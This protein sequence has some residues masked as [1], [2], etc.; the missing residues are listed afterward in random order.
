MSFNIMAVV[1]I[2]SDF[3]NAKIKSVTVSIISPSICYEEMRLETMIFIFQMLSFK[4]KFSLS[5]FIKRLFRSSSLSATR[6]VL[7]A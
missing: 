6:V 5:S 1:T 2:C 4:P 3:W 7:S